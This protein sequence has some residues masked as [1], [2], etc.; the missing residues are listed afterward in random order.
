MKLAKMSKAAIFGSIR[1]WTDCA[2]TED[3]NAHFG[4]G[5]TVAVICYQFL[6]LGLQTQQ[7]SVLQMVFVKNHTVLIFD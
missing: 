1:F 5:G 7:T 4:A 2:N 3:K 6:S